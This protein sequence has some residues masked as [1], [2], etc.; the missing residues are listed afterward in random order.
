MYKS[1]TW[2]VHKLMSIQPSKFDQND[3]ATNKQDIWLTRE[4]TEAELQEKRRHVWFAAFDSLWQP[5]KALY[6]PAGVKRWAY[7]N[8]RK[9]LQFTKISRFS[10]VTIA[11]GNCRIDPFVASIASRIVHLIQITRRFCLPRCSDTFWPSCWKKNQCRVTTSRDVGGW[12][13][14]L[15]VGVIDWQFFKINVIAKFSKRNSLL[16]KKNM[17]KHGEFISI[18]KQTNKLKYDLKNKAVWETLTI[19][20]VLP[21]CSCSSVTMVINRDVSLQ[22]W[23]RPRQF[24]EPP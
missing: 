17:F 22:I 13:K 11:K 20:S 23:R 12:K 19:L 6:A 9:N 7:K 24:Y 8:W 21:T 10:F 15:R 2:L 4:K 3:S 18:V 14:L 1:C 5:A 16:L